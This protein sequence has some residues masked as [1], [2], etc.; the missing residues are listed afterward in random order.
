[1]VSWYS[2]VFSL[3]SFFGMLRE[4]GDI[5]ANP[6]DLLAAPKRASELPAVCIH[7][8]IERQAAAVHG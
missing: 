5:P 7:E 4:H 8:L 3:R 2:N 1:M 6:A